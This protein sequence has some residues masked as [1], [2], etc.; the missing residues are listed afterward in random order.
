MV[1]VVMKLSD[2]KI[3][4]VLG[5]Y[6]FHSME[7]GIKQVYTQSNAM[8]PVLYDEN[9]SDR[10]NVIY[11]GDD[12]LLEDVLMFSIAMTNAYP[13]L[14]DIIYYWK[15]IDMDTGE[16]IDLMEELADLLGKESRH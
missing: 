16:V 2:R 5:R 9:F 6:I 13:W 15:C 10:D 1:Q 8:Y 14:K 3:T 12:I 11:R 7:L 4:P